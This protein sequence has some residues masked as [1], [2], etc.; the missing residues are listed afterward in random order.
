MK[1]VFIADAHLHLPE[2]ANYQRL[3]TFLGSLEGQV[4]TLY[5]LGDIFQFW[6]G[7]RHCVFANAVP[8][9]AALRR[10][11]VAGTRLVYVE[12]NHDFKLGPYFRDTLACRVI[13]DSADIE[14][15]GMRVHLAHGDLVDPADSGYRLLRTTLRSWP[16]QVFKNLIPPDW[17]WGISVWM[18]RKSQANHHLRDRA[19]RPLQLLEGYFEKRCAAG[20]QA[21]VTGHFHTPLIK[22]SER[23]TLV[24]LGDWITQYSYAVFENG[25]FTLHQA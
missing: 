9:L 11:H 1:D 15:D 13:P 8:L 14:I 6:V 18:N 20:A 19:W 7:Y 4:R 2:D 24:A 10:L 25:R 12:G 21:V 17:M 5:L 22:V 3:L 23:G 16:L